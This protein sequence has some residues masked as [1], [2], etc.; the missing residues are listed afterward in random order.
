MIF[1]GYLQK[2]ICIFCIIALQLRNRII[3][4]RKIQRMLYFRFCFPIVR[5]TYFNLLFG[6]H[7]TECKILLRGYK[8]AEKRTHAR[9]RSRLLAPWI[10]V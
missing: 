2:D 10:C 8:F 3:E 1:F 9:A 4:N 7:A 6:P 5:Y